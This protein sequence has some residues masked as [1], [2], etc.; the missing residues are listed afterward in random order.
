MTDVVAVEV[1]VRVPVHVLLVAAADQITARH[2]AFLHAPSA[3]TFNTST[4]TSY[5][6]CHP[7]DA[8]VLLAI[9]RCLSVWHKSEFRRSV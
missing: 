7:R 6:Y 9:A 3:A 4:A 2:D 5:G 8:S 1:V